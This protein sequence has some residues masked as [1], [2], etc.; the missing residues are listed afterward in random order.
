M[1]MKKE[2]DNKKYLENERELLE[3]KSVTIEI[4]SIEGFKYKMKENPLWCTAKK[5]KKVL[6][7]KWQISQGSLL[8]NKEEFWKEITKWM[9]WNSLKK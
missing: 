6:G 4:N 8:T 5:K 3:F 7:G 9:R 1:S 2:H